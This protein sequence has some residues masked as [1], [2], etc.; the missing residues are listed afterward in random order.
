[1]NKAV[2]YAAMVF[3]GLGLVLLAL[4]AYFLYAPAPRKPHLSGHAVKET[5]RI[6]SRI[7][8]YIEYAPAGLPSGSPLVIVLHGRW[9]SAGRMREVTGYEFDAEADKEHFAVLYPEGFRQSWSD[10]RKGRQETARLE[11][12]DDPGFIRALIAREAADRKI[13]VHKVFVVGLS[14]GGHMAMDLAEMSPSPIAAAAVFG[15]SEPVAVESECPRNTPTVPIMIVDGTADPI[16]P[17]D[18]GEVVLFGLQ[19]IGKV[20]P[21]L[22][23]AEDFA[24]RDGVAASETTTDLPH[25]HADDPTHVHEMAWSRDGKPYVVLYE[26]IGG[27]HVV[28]QPSY[29]YPRMF[30]RTSEDLDGP[31]AAVAFF[32]HR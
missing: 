17:F 15:A 10:C 21:A 9:M 7:R 29:R 19:R 5:M 6:G 28:P 26:V 4:Y 32:L 11:H 2:S 22:A 31:A 24:R 8:H 18:G 30:G 14:N 13:D 27:G 20:M 16:N 3:I 12:I 25:L 1:M 23:S